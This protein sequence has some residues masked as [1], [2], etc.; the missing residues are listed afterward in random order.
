LK[1][2]G[3]CVGFFYT[4]KVLKIADVIEVRNL[5]VLAKSLME[6]FLTGLH[7]SPFHGYSVEFAEYRNYIRGD[8]FRHVDWKLYGRTEKLFVKKFDDET[9]LRVTLM[10]DFSGSMKYAPEQF[11][12]LDLCVPLIVGLLKI[13]QKQRDAFQLKSF[14]DHLI[15][16]TELKSTYHHFLRSLGVLENWVA[17]AK[18][19]VGQKTQLAKS[20][21]E[22]VPKLAKRS[23]IILFSDGLLSED[24]A[25]LRS[26]FGKVQHYGH[27]LVWIQPV[28][29][30][31]E[32]EFHLP[33][34][35]LKL[36]DL[37]T[38]TEVKTTPGDWEA[39]ARQI[40]GAKQKEL[41][42][43]LI[44]FGVE[45]HYL[46]LEDDLNSLFIKVLRKREKL[47]SKK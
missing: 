9:N 27:E 37:E 20:L 44:S 39:D 28:F 36:V 43:L 6:G 10:L 13:F 23:L 1:A 46:D 19:S 45:H 34:R 31:Q 2:N 42:E 3:T 30:K 11:S 8:S 47:L 24:V 35:P 7:K 21:D 38:G 12:K 16:E 5:E 26:V 22:L 41:A 14:S 25:D 4:L 33:N 18:G 32:L 15:A 29:E 40:M 17:D